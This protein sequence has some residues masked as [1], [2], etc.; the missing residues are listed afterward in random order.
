VLRTRMG[1]PH[2]RL[3][4]LKFYQMRARLRNEAITRRRFHRSIAERERSG[5]Q[6]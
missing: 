4:W 5:R 3:Q 6:R 2:L 1:I